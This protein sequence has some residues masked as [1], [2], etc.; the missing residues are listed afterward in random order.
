[1]WVLVLLMRSWFFIMCLVCVIGMLEN[2]FV[3]S[4]DAKV[5]VGVRGICR[6]SRIRSVDSLC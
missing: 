1:M 3:M 2:M 6:S 5:G 4:R